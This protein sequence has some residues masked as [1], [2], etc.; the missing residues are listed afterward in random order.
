MKT[1]YTR[2]A[3]N[4]DVLASLMLLKQMLG[5]DHDK[6][7]ELC[8]VKFAKQ[9]SESLDFD[10]YERFMTSILPS[11]K[12]NIQIYGAAV[13]TGAEEAMNQYKNPQSKPNSNNLQHAQPQA[14]FIRIKL[15]L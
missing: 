7:A 14:N 11:E 1:Q 4:R 12:E 9:G 15:R 2:S 3:A 8:G 13:G 10:T 5:T 6:R